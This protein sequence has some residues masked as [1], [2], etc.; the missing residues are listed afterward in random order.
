MA[1][2]QDFLNSIGGSATPPKAESQPSPLESF[3][4]LLDAPYQ[5]IGDGLD[6]AYDN[7]I[8]DWTGTRDVFSGKDLRIIPELLTLGIPGGL[9]LKGLRAAAN[10]SRVSKFGKAVEEAMKVKKI[11]GGAPV[12]GA[13]E[14]AKGF[15]KAAEDAAQGVAPMVSPVP[16]YRIKGSTGGYSPDRNAVL[17][18]LKG[19]SDSWLGRMFNNNGLSLEKLPAGTKV[20]PRSYTGTTQSA[21]KKTVGSSAKGSSAAAT[22]TIEAKRQANKESREKAKQEK[23]KQREAKAE[24]RRKEL[25][26]RYPAANYVDVFEGK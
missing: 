22:G 10:M 14:A 4:N 11:P 19:Q 18:E 26:A 1:T 2:S 3:L 21:A 20:D 13:S 24:A 7:T 17:R 15:R 5:T 8:G 23:Q 12:T 25:Q 9:A 6:W 16:L